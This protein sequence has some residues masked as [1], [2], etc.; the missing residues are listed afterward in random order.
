MK[1]IM[2]FDEVGL[3]D[4]SLVGGKC[5]NLGELCKIGVPVPP[6]FAITTSVFDEFVENERI[7]DEIR[8]LHVFSK[9]LTTINE[10]EEAS[11]L[12]RQLIESKALPANLTEPIAEA[13]KMLCEKCGIEDMAVAV[14]SSG[15]AEDMPTASFAGQYDSYLNIKGIENVLENVKKCWSSMFTARCMHYRKHN[16]LS[17]IEG[18]ISVAVQKMVNAEAA[19]VCFSVNPNTG[20]RSKI[21][22]EGNWGAG[23]SVVQG[24]V[25]PDIFVIDKN[26]MDLLDV[27]VNKK[28]T[29]YSLKE[30]GTEVEAVPV[31]KQSICCLK[32]EEAQK[33][34]GIAK[35]LE[36]YYGAPQDTEWV[37]DKD[38]KF[39][40]NVFLVQSRPITAISEQK[41]TADKLV[42]LM[43]SRL[44]S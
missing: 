15:V 22:L 16:G 24:H 18:S 34:A 36:V 23:E 10:F 28:L 30:H 11:A 21:V 7:F 42:D 39:P 4:V 33:I 6:G 20:D 41:D 26:T 5:T 12:I 3:G 31:E 1:K 17:I 40:N 8:Q 43:L 44:I 37:I 14:R 35:S 38:L 32:N 13:Y 27:K 19:G 29:Q 9:E 25:N 2:W